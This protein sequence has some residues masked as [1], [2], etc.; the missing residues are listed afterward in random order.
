[1]HIIALT[2]GI[3]SGKSTVSRR[4]ADHGAAIIDA[5]QLAREA[6]EPG[7]SALAAISAAFGDRVIAADGSLDRAALGRIVFS[8]DAARLT[9]NSITHPEVW[10]LARLRM[11]EAEDAGYRVAVY[12]V[13]LLAEAAEER[14]LRFDAVVVVTAPEDERIR[15]MV[16]QRGMTEADARAR[17]AA[18]LPDA[19]RLALA[20][21]VLDNSGSPDELREKVDELWASLPGEGEPG[22]PQADG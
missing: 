9:L 8:D 14:L 20:D 1:M 11:A 17:I 7:T 18:Q 22:H 6:V 16:G 19:A 4:L 15:R 3:A 10:R 21:V 5:D 2:G 13:P 12:D